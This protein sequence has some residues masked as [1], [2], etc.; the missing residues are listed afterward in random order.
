M[1]RIYKIAIIAA[2][3]LSQNLFSQAPDTLWTKTFGG[4][5]TDIGNSVIQSEDGGFVIVGV[6]GFF[7]TGGTDVWLI[8]TDDSGV[9][10]WSKTFGGVNIDLGYSV[11]QTTDGGY[12]ITG[13]TESFGAGDTDVYLIKTDDSGVELW[14]KAFGGISYDVG[15][16]VQQ[17]EDGGYIITGYT[18]SFGAGGTNVYLI[19]TDDSGAASWT[20]T[21]GGVSYDFGYSVQQTTD[22][23]YIIAGST[24][25]FSSGNS[26]VWLIKTNASGVELWTKTFGGVNIDLSY[27]VQQTTDGGYILAG[28]TESFGAGNSDVWLIKTNASGVELWTK[29]FGGVYYDVGYSVQQ[30]TGGGYII[31]GY[32]ESFGAAGSDVYLIKTDDSGVEL[33]TKTFGGNYNEVGYSVQQTEDIGYIVTGIT[34][35]FGA[36][37]SDVYLIKTTSDSSNIGLINSKTISEFLLHQNYPN[38]FNPRTTISYSIPELSSV[39]LKVYDVLG[40]EI[41]TLVNEEKPIG[42]YEFEFDATALP[43]GIYFLQMIAGNYV[44]TKKMVLLK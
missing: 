16:S 40:N 30:T 21:F 20:K 23:G 19:K 24:K 28:R 22:G 15:Y 6:T 2:L 35:S 42:T 38:P 5:L 29:T 39:V 9:E 33:W 7:G 32:T 41:E 3:L 14:T 11:Q 17:T 18:E 25:S 34:D 10:L 8:K 13:Y 36:G 37:N 31:I 12:I 1:M 26:D 44:E 27:S 4:N 43:S